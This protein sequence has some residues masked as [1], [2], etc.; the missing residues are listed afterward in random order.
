V[1]I[2]VL[3]SGGVDSS[4]ALAL[5]A[6]RRPE[7]E[8][9][10]FYLKIWLEDELAHLGACPWEEDLRHAR[11][12]TDELAVPLEVLSL[13]RAYHERV[14]AH[15]LAELAAGR[16]PSPDLHCNERV[17]FGA[18]VD[19]VGADFDR[20]ATGHYARAL[21]RDGRVRL[22]MA[23]DPVKDQTYFLSRLSPA[24][25]ARVEFPLGD[26]EKPHVRTIAREL[27]LAT[28]DRKDSQGIC[29]LGKIP[30][31]E[32]VR[33]HLGPCPGDI[34]DID[35]RRVLARHA[36]LWFFTIGQ[37]KGLGLG[38]GPWF[39]VDKDVANRTLFVAHA[40]R[41]AEHLRAD[42]EVTELRWL[43]DPP[44]AGATLRLKLR[45]GPATHPCVLE[46]SSNGRT[47]VRLAAPEPG[48]A[49]GQF[50]VFYRDLPDAP[51]ECLGSGMI[52]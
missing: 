37:R 3:V 24:Q 11:A 45:H 9:T 46:P 7:V 17:K 6:L 48:I 51:P 14:V 52:S 42:F 35:S 29:F 23:A 19:A 28:H 47:L 43:A 31:P 33:H 15:A 22:H 21:R 4:V 18:F 2:A 13:Q 50:A 10:A 12:V 44:P 36:G 32:F 41:L 30:Y 26:H 27:G 25:L 1:K 40:T 34:V 20:V 39:V 16:T 38:G 8:L 49:P 5:L